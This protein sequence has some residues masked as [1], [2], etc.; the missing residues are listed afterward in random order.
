MNK[1]SFFVKI[2]PE[3]WRFFQKPGGLELDVSFTQ[4]YLCLQDAK[5]LPAGLEKQALRCLATDS[6]VAFFLV[7]KTDKLL[8]SVVQLQPV[9]AGVQVDIILFKRSPEA[10]DEY[11]VSIH[12]GEVN[13]LP[14][15]ELT[16]SGVPCRPM[17]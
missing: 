1:A 15:S 13:W 2:L 4:I 9:F 3:G 10:L 8:Y 7:V 11:N 16:I 6:L 17:A 12:R 5:S 14:W